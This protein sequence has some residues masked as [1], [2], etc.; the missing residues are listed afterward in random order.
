MPMIT[1]FIPKDEKQLEILFASLA[2]QTGFEYL[3]CCLDK[4]GKRKSSPDAYYR[5][6]RTK[7]NITC[8]FKLRIG[9][10]ASFKKNGT[11]DMVVAYEWGVKK[12]EL[13]ERIRQ[14]LIDKHKITMPI[15]IVCDVPNVSFIEYNHKNMVPDDFNFLER[16]NFLL[17]NTKH[18]PTIYSAYLFAKFPDYSFSRQEITEKLKI[19]FP[20]IKSIPGQ[21]IQ[22]ILQPLYPGNTHIP[23]P[24]IS[25][26][27]GKITYCQW[28]SDFSIA[29]ALKAIISIYEDRCRF[30]REPG[31]VFP[32]LPDTNKL[33]EYAK[34][35][36]PRF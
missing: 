32:K 9:S 2:E 15:L 28:N 33:K 4:N 23:N 14:G 13:Q 30:D 8:E 16:L 25:K 5:D 35:Q 17:S 21:G 29:N 24:V 26:R 7:K 27:M 12:K 6:M 3:G 34:M 22:N 19:L 36:Y 31:V 11:F 20:Y 18:I 1:K 10:L